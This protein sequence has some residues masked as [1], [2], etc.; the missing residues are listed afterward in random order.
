MLASAGEGRPGQFRKHL[1]SRLEEEAIMRKFNFRGEGC[2]CRQQCRKARYKRS[3]M[4]VAPK[5]LYRTVVPAESLDEIEYMYNCF[6]PIGQ[7]VRD[8]SLC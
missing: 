1:L 8:A 6:G 3:Q 5:E 4:A 2:L 7:F